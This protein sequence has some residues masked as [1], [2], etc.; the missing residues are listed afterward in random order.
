MVWFGVGSHL[1]VSLRPSHELMNPRNLYRFENNMRNTVRGIIYTYTNEAYCYRRRSMVCQCVC[2]NREP[3]K[4]SSTDRGALWVVDSGRP[5]EAQVQSYSPGGAWYCLLI[6][7]FSMI[8][9][10]DSVLRVGRRCRESNVRTLRWLI[11]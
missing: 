9:R 6:P 11:W 10:K 5:K 1:A 4:N 7:S 3:C 2:H 8:S